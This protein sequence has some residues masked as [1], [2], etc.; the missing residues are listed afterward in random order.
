MVTCSQSFH[1]MEP[2]STIAEVSRVLRHGGVFAIYDYDWPPIIDWVMERDYKKLID[3]CN[4]LLR[5]APE[6]N[7][8]K[9]WDKRKHH[10]NI[11]ESARFRFSREI[12]LHSW[13]KSDA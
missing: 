6:E 5:Q 3:G 8:V 4:E 13:E 12:A 10:S 9:Q 1:W 11:I 2:A 7:R